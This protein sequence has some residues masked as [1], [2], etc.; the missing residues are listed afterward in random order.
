MLPMVSRYEQLQNGSTISYKGRARDVGFVVPPGQ[1]VYMFRALA[2]FAMT[3]PSYRAVL[4]L[5]LGM[6]AASLPNNVP[7]AL[8][9]AG[10]RHPALAPTAW[11]ILVRS[12][13]LVQV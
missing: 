4:A 5:L 1:V 7:V 12:P 13:P 9:P 8:S 10:I 6:D 2:P 3:T 11:K